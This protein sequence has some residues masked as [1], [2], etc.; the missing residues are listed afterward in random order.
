MIIYVGLFS[1]PLS[2]LQFM[3]R[4]MSQHVFCHFSLHCVGMLNLI[5]VRFGKID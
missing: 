3:L 5:D 4:V 1:R 2:L